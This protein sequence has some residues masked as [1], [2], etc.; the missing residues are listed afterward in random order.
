ML[1]YS[2]LISNLSSIENSVLKFPEPSNNSILVN[3]VFKFPS[4]LASGPHCVAISLQLAFLLFSSSRFFSSSSRLFSSSFFLF[5]S[6]FNNLSFSFFFFC[7]SFCFSLF[8]FS[9]S[10]SCIRYS[11]SALSRRSASILSKYSRHI[12]LAGPSF[13]ISPSSIQI[14]RSQS[15]ST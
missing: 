7:S 2:I 11:S 12:C 10:S 4:R 6:S 9:S 1:S 15:F 8:L 5:C 13:L 3:L 14:A